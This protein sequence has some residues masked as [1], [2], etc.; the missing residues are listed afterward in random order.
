MVD[1]N[2]K[3]KK[4]SDEELL[5]LF[6]K[7]LVKFNEKKSENPNY[8]EE[9]HRL[10][11]DKN[12]KGC[13]HFGFNPIELKR[14]SMRLD[15]FHLSCATTRKLADYLCQYMFRQTVEI[16]VEFNDM[17]VCFWGEFK[18]TWWN[19]DWSLAEFKGPELKIFI[20]NI[21][22][23]KEFILYRQG[24]CEEANRIAEGLSLWYK[25]VPFLNIAYVKDKASYPAKVT[26]F[27]SDAKKLYV[28][29][30]K[31]FLS[32]EYV[33]DEEMFTV[34]T[35]GSTCQSLRV[36]HLKSMEQDLG[37]LLCRALNIEIKRATDIVTGK[38]T[39]KEIFLCK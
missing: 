36:K 20:K 19:L 16:Q 2:H 38:P 27:E 32:T 17:L 10:Y 25:I 14:S 7:S 1:L 39:R 15:S 28:V 9:H 4:L 6:D 22:F 37:C 31:T 12:L 8:H 13:T 21:L 24:G 34:T 35:L 3:Y 11:V 23:M 26:K 18:F 33:G 5:E 29:G 30:A